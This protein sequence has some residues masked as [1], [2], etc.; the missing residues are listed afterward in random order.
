MFRDSDGRFTRAWVDSAP[1]DSSLQVTRTIVVFHVPSLMPPGVI[2]RKRHI[3][4]DNI[5]I[6]FQESQRISH[7]GLDSDDASQ[8]GSTDSVVS[9]H[10][11]FVTIHVVE[12]AG[13]AMVRVSVRVRQDIPRDL[14]KALVPFAGTSMVTLENTPEFVRRIAILADLACRATLENL[15]PATNMYERFKML[16]LMGRHILQ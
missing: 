7:V 2:N 14:H 8:H 5:L 1:E 3:G 6:V 11:G 16:Q 4:N 12:L 9:G 15:A 13:H 10:F